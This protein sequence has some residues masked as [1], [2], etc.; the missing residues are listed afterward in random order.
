MND[1]KIDDIVAMLDQFMS[2]KGGHMNITVDPNGTIHAEKTVQ[3]TNSLECAPGN[4]AC[5]VPTLFEGLDT[6]NNN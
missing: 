3:K 4:M 5:K 2:E 6:E 1:N